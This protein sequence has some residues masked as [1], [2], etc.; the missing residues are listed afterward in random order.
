MKRSGFAFCLLMFAIMLI[1]GSAKAQT[2]EF[3]YQGS[4]QNSSAPANG[5][6]DFEFLLFDAASG[7]AQ[8]GSTLTRS[9]VA[10]ANGTFA[11][12]LDFGSQFPGSSRFLEIHV[13]PTGGGAYTPLAPRQPVSNSP[14]A[15]RSLNAASADTATNA[16]NAVNAT[17]AAT[18]TNATQLGGVAA[19]QYVLTGDARL[20]DAR[21]PTA[22]ST[23]YIQNDTGQQA[24]SNFNI[25]GNGT[26]GGTLSANI[27]NATTQFNIGGNRVLS[28]PG[29]SNLFAGVDS[30]LVNTTGI[31]NTF[32]G[33]GAGRFTDTGSRNIFIGVRVGSTNTTGSNNTVIGDGADVRFGN[34][35]NATAV[36]SGAVVSQSNSLVLGRNNINVGIGSNAPIFKLHVVGENV[37]V[38]GN[39]LNV[40]PRFS[41]Y[42]TGGVADSGKWQNYATNGAL[43]FGAVNDAENLETIWLNVVRTGLAVS[44]IEF[45]S[46]PV[47][48]GTLGSVGG[49]ALCRNLSN[50][51]STCS[52][53]LRYKTNLI[54]YTSGLSVV[55]RLSPIS[56]DW[57]AGG[58]RDFGFGAEDV[59]KIDPLLV[60]YNDKGQVEGVKYDRVGVVL[61]NAVKEQQAQI[62]AQQAQIEEQ[63]ARIEAQQRQIELLMKIVCSQ[64]KNAVVCRDT[65]APK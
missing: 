54:P 37:R 11:V 2:T 12:K 17:N 27:L 30:G 5:N 21:Q 49:T 39:D 64:K 55:N 31:N 47:S 26:A 20:S 23:S 29:S 16:T 44:R 3:T 61:V 18:A 52:S 22:G 41:L 25:S 14:Y 1:V 51:I 60:T 63:N 15:V 59:E 4:L 9:S 7:G 56:F 65:A 36:G 8:I 50:E 53:S 62:E 48:I 43:R 24:S 35:T 19:N 28:I 32:V 42:F 34:L 38:E 45:L 58:R 10:V 33:Q 57:K 6:F 13:R 46:A 40:L